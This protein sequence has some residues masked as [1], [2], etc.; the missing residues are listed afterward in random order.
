MIMM[1]NTVL[2]IVLFSIILSGCTDPTNAR[3]QLE[4]AGY[5]NIRLQGY[6]LFGCSEDDIIHDGFTAVGQQGKF[7]N[8]VVCGGYLKGS[9]IRLY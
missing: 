8:G 9:T 3:R 5:T 4:A 6:V 1:K 2:K 7:V